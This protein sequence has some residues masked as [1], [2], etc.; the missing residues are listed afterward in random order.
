MEA[1]NVRWVH[2][3][4]AKIRKRRHDI[5]KPAT[6]RIVVQLL[7]H[8]ELAQRMRPERMEYFFLKDFF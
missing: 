3:I 7:A 6:N 5:L 1:G 2:L 4:R 8:A